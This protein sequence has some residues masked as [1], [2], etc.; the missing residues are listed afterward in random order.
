[1]CTMDNVSHVLSP[2]GWELLNSSDEYFYTIRR[3]PWV[4][5][6]GPRTPPPD[7]SKTLR[8]V[9]CQT[10]SEWASFRG[11][12]NDKEAARGRPPP[13]ERLLS[14]G[15]NRLQ[16]A[17]DATDKESPRYKIPKKF[18]NTAAVRIQW[19]AD[20]D[21]DEEESYTWSLLDA[22]IGTRRRSWAGATP[23][24]SS[25]SLERHVSAQGSARSELRSGMRRYDV[26]SGMD[27]LR[28]KKMA[29]RHACTVVWCPPGD[30]A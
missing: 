9:I 25:R 23:Q 15:T 18:R 10:P 27:P 3:H 24:N 21:Y 5:D 13:T 22:I 14:I 6:G 20:K 17:N 30:V 4:I 19:P 1:M 2:E 11:L 8:D 26:S 12:E 29:L 28:Q 16:I 7:R